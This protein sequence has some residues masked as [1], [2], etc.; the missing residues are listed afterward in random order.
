MGVARLAQVVVGEDAETCSRLLKDDF[1]CRL[2]HICPSNWVDLIHLPY[3]LRMWM[4]L[5][6]SRVS[7]E[8]C[9]DGGHDNRTLSFRDL[10]IQNCFVSDAVS[11]PAPPTDINSARF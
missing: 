6:T 5:E 8:S 9:H 2:L 4:V 3:P 10:A 7:V 11:H 1:F